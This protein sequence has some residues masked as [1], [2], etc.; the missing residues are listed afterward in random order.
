[1]QEL[2]SKNFDCHAYQ[3]RYSVY[4]YGFTTNTLKD[5]ISNEGLIKEIQLHKCYCKF[6]LLKNILPIYYSYNNDISKLTKAEFCRVLNA[7]HEDIV[8]KCKDTGEFK[9]ILRDLYERENHIE[10][11]GFFTNSRE[12]FKEDSDAF[13]ILAKNALYKNLSTFCESS[14]E[15]TKSFCRIDEAK[16]LGRGLV[17]MNYKFFVYSFYGLKE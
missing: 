3:N 5:V 2:S 14:P 8:N 6:D 12:Y 1:M 16:G 13:R 4:Q 9:K 7:S 17:N 10:N 15:C 11:Y